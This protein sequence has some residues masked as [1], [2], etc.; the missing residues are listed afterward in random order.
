MKTNQSSAH[1]H[2]VSTPGQL[3][4]NIKS[5]GGRKEGTELLRIDRARPGNSL[6]LS[7]ALVFIRL[8][9]YIYF[10]TAKATAPLVIIVSCSFN[11]SNGTPGGIRTPDL[12]LR[13]QPLYPSE[14]QAL[15]QGV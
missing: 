6:L 11:G 3:S 1:F 10:V 5:S 2:G 4:P 14:L 9:N 15:S 13:R 7:Y 8:T 12:L